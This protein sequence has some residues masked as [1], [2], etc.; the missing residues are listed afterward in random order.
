[1]CLDDYPY[2]CPWKHG[3]F[4]S[5]YTLI[6]S[7]GTSFSSAIKAFHY[8]NL[9]E[10]V[11]LY[12]RYFGQLGYIT[13]QWFTGMNGQS[14]PF[15]SN[16]S[17]RV[18][19]D[20]EDVASLDYSLYLSQAIGTKA[21]EERP[22]TPWS[23]RFFGHLADGGGYFTTI[24]IPFTKE[25]KITVQND[26]STG[27]LWYI[28]RGLIGLPLIIGSF[29]IPSSSRLRLYKQDKVLS[30]FEFITL[31]NSTETGG[32]LFL[33]TLNVQSE[34][35]QFMEG[36]MRAVIDSVNETSFLSSGTEDFFL[37]AYYFN[38]GEYHGFQAGLTFK[39]NST[40]N[41]QI[42]AYKLFVDDPV[43]F[44]KSFRL[45]WRN[46]EKLGGPDGCPTQFPA[47]SNS[48]KDQ[49]LPKKSSSEPAEAH[50][51]SYVWVYEWRVQN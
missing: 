51:Q 38:S 32:M 5:G 41:T 14:G 6:P 23:T 40:K 9:G 29:Q 26:V 13:E 21:K 45:I 31:S 48:R 2:Y 27:Y 36:C 43:V 37:S 24:R 46:N 35:P 50:I 33:V 18:Y 44:S 19:I 8:E 39:S 30:P 15:D 22:N 16:A 11:V 3:L 17:V 47:S 10:E 4:S 12:K 20:G 42:V 25:I 28:V 7:D 34:S 49:P 1:M